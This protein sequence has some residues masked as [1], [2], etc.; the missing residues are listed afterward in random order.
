VS[1][2][3]VLYWLSMGVL[4]IAPLGFAF[5]FSTL[6]FFDGPRGD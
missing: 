2:A 6:G 1:K 3:Q 4:A 5:K